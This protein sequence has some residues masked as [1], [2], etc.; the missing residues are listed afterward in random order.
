[1][2][3]NLMLARLFDRKV[4]ITKHSCYYRS[5][6]F[7]VLWICL[8][9]INVMPVRMIVNLRHSNGNKANILHEDHSIK[10]SHHKFRKKIPEINSSTEIWPLRSKIA[11]AP[12]WK[13][14][15]FRKIRKKSGNYFCEKMSQLYKFRKTSVVKLYWSAFENWSRPKNWLGGYLS[16][17]DQSRLENIGLF[18]KGWRL[19]H[20][21]LVPSAYS[22]ETT[23]KTG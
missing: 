8:L 1:M 14:W 10:F 17:S 3:L 13:K 11:E 9:V 5:W 16:G 2:H 23:Q 22:L 7:S 19:N 15:H 6:T 18:F 12:F 4:I 20:L 21:W